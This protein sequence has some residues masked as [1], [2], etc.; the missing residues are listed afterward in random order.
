MCLGTPTEKHLV[1][2]WQKPQSEAEDYD[3]DNYEI[4][5]IRT[6]WFYV[7]VTSK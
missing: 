2:P 6:H 3:N 1:S 7:H 4:R 5:G